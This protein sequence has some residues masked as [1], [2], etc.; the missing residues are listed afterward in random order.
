MP[1]AVVFTS[2]FDTLKR[3]CYKIKEMFE[4]ADKLLDFQNLPGVMHGYQSNGL[5]SETHWFYKEAGI[6]FKKYVKS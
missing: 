4:K 3:D 2:E 1:P 5:L 6:A